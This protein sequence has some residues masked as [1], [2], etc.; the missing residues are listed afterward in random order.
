M[1][2]KCRIR[3][4]LVTILSAMGAAAHADP[5]QLLGGANTGNYPGTN[6]FFFDGD[7]LAGTTD[8]G[9]AASWQG[10]GSPFYSPNQFGSLSFA[11][12]RGGINFG[13]PFPLLGIEFLGGPLLDLDG[14]LQNPTRSVAPVATSPS[15]F[16]S[17]PVEIPNTSSF[18]DLTLD[19]PGQ[20]ISLNNFDATG[21]NA[22]SS[23][24]SPEFGVSVN[25][26]AGTP[27]T[28]AGNTA[29][30]G[31]AI[32][33][34]DDRSGSLTAETGVSGTLTGVY[35]VN[36]LG[37]EIWNDSISPNAST[38]EL[39]TFQTLGELSGL[40]IQRASTSDP[41][42]S[43][44]GE[45]GGTIWPAVAG[46]PGVD[47]ISSIT[48]LPVTISGFDGAGLPLTGEGDATMDL[49]AYLDL[50]LADYADAD[51]LELVYLQS[52]GFGIN[53]SSDPAFGDTLSYDMVIVAQ[54]LADAPAVPTPA[55]FALGICGM[56]VLAMR[57]GRA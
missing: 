20:S 54:R 26:L 8:D 19:I 34:I 14:D 53:N 28:F 21:T 18:I 37:F 25:H 16:S 43:L 50:V 33:T 17:N 3:L 22:G 10:T 2:P 39:G 30:P 55:T 5:Y 15:T 31:P 32:N 7:R 56:A 27:G 23:G 51:A 52:A 1:N 9:P 48:G 6:S 36:N 13:F 4:V 29:N 40:V 11:Y 24:L 35:R 57:R 42:P 44:A 45:V 46:L 47:P 41:W 49:G 12:R 38:P